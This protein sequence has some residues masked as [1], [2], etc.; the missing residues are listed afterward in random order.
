M[1][2]GRVRWL[3]AVPVSQVIILLY[4]SKF[5]RLL[6]LT[7]HLSLLQH[8]C[9]ILLLLNVV[10]IPKAT[11]ASLFQSQAEPSSVYHWTVGSQTTIVMLFHF[12]MADLCCLTFAY[13][14]RDDVRMSIE[15]C[16]IRVADERTPSHPFEA[17]KI[18]SILLTEAGRGRMRKI[19][20][21]P[22]NRYY[23]TTTTVSYGRF[24]PLYRPSPPFFGVRPELVWEKAL[25]LK[26]VVLITSRRHLLYLC[27]VGVPSEGEGPA[28]ADSLPGVSAWPGSFPGLPHVGALRVDL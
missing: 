27:P 16:H 5:T 6:C 8:L 4:W 10:L 24:P 11:S 13:A 18:T 23:G 17:T 3:K 22:K 25:A 14:L 28:V 9:F 26:D 20:S 15:V 2:L 19:P 12:L 1:L 21:T 7:S